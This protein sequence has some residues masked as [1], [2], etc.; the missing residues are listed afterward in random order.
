MVPSSPAPPASWNLYKQGIIENHPHNYF[1]QSDLTAFD[2]SK[3]EAAGSA[4][5]AFVALPEVS[6]FLDT[7]PILQYGLGG[8]DTAAIIPGY[9]LSGSTDSVRAGAGTPILG[10]GSAVAGPVAGTLLGLAF[11]YPQLAKELK[12]HN[13]NNPINAKPYKDL[14]PAEAGLPQEAPKIENVPGT[15]GVIVKYERNF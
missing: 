8:L 2:L 9:L 7:H 10:F 15:S 1:F 6:K 4:I 12:I 14:T 3:T 11:K 13:F 5:G